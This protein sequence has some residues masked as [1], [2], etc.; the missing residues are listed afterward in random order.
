MFADVVTLEKLKSNQNKTATYS[1]YMTFAYNV[2]NSV[3]LFVIGVLLDLI[4]FNPSEPVQAIKVQN[5][6]GIIVLVGCIVSIGLSMFIFN[7]Y[8]LTRAEI[9]KEQ[10]R[11]KKANN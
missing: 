3:S 2:A 5:A 6:L 7:K 11:A 1:G 4:K 8:K 9:L 10:M